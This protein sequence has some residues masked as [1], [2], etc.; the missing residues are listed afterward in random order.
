MLGLD[1]Q[2]VIRKDL[3]D[4]QGKAIRPAKPDNSAALRLSHMKRRYGVRSAEFYL[5]L[6]HWIGANPRNEDDNL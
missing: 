6:M 2:E 4:E 1:S 3:V 5:R